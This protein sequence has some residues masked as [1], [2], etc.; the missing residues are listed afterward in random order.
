MANLKTLL[1]SPGTP[2]EVS[3]LCKFVYDRNL[4]ELQKKPSAL[5]EEEYKLVLDYLNTTHPDTN[6]IHHNT[7]S[8]ANEVGTVVT[9]WHIVHTKINIKGKLYT[10]HRRHIGNSRISFFENGTRWYGCILYIFTLHDILDQFPDYFIVVERYAINDQV[11]QD[12]PHLNTVM[13]DSL[14]CNR[15]ITQ[16]QIKAHCAWFENNDSSLKLLVQLNSLAL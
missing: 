12:W 2:P 11:S 16:D 10:T 5:L 3:K 4:R 6:W 14:D 7:V 15:I 1:E 13:V 8:S 9:P